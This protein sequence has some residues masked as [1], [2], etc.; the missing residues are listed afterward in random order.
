VNP[1]V[2]TMKTFLRSFSLFLMALTIYAGANAQ[3]TTGLVFSNPILDSGVSNSVNA[4][5][6]FQ[7]VATG[8]NARIKIDSAINGAEVKKI[9]DN[10][11][12]L[13]YVN[14]FQP[15]IKIPHGTAK[16]YVVFTV[17][18]YDATTNA[19]KTLSQ[20]EATALDIDGNATVKEY[21]EIAMGGGTVS[22][23]QG[24]L[25]ILLQSI[26]NNYAA[27]NFMGIE[28]NGIDTSALGN[29]FT[30]SRSNISSYKLK[31][32]ATTLLSGSTNRQFSV[33]MKGFNYNSTLPVKLASFTATLTTTNKADLKWVTASE[34]NVSH[35]TIEK[36]LDGTNFSEAGMMFAYGN[37]SDKTN[38]S[39]S[40]N[41]ANST[42]TV[43][44]YRLK[45]VDID[46][47]FEYSEI[48]V[49]RIGKNRESN[50]S[51]LTYPNPAQNELRITIPASW[52]NKIVSYE[53]F[54]ATGQVVRK[55]QTPSSSQT[56]TIN[57]NTMAP[58]FYIVKVSCGTESAQQRIVKQ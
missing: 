48:R 2:K 26:F 37:S 30:V 33:Y 19:V 45:S 40:D 23:S 14:A 12:G 34:I 20:T 38:Y 27:Q 21:A 31:L 29:M 5:Y 28:R 47:K 32:G 25:D 42:S 13:G 1:K 8:V 44:Y 39:F 49:I 54:S 4:V 17:Q 35:F 52:Q 50:I 36:S 43:I 41:L 9:D 18:F 7:N 3:S 10:S 51:I 24:T 22:Y 56:E 15:E 53:L 55:T 46:G 57:L 6:L 16:A 11:N 58:G